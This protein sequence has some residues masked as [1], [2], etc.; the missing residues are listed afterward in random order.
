LADFR[1]PGIL[2][3]EKL[4]VDFMALFSQHWSSGV[5]GQVLRERQCFELCVSLAW[6][7]AHRQQTRPQVVPGPPSKREFI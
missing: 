1:W 5:F 2:E 6:V 4:A 7:V 3:D